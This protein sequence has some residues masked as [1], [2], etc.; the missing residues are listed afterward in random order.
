MRRPLHVPW[1]RE[2]EREAVFIGGLKKHNKIGFLSTNQNQTG[3]VTTVGPF[4]LF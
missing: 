1:E 3:F 2:R 4:F